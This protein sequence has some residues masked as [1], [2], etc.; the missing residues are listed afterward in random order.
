[1][2]ERYGFDKFIIIVLEMYVF[3][4][5]IIV[6]IIRFQILDSIDSIESI[7]LYMMK[8]EVNGKLV[9]IELE[10]VNLLISFLCEELLK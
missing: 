10:F 3:V 7:I 9:D 5:N 4:I 8:L 1:M 2:L 6:D